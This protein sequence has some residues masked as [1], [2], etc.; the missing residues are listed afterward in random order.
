MRPVTP[1]G[2]VRPLIEIERGEVEQFL[3]D[4]G[5][6]W[7]EDASNGDPRFARN[8]IRHELLPRLTQENPALT[9]TLARQATVAA[10][11]E[12][13]WEAEIERVIEGRLVLRP[14]AVLFRVD[15]VRS[16]APAVARRAIRRAVRAA[17]GD[18]RSIDME[19]VERILELTSW[20]PPGQPG[21]ARLQ[22]PGLDV[23]RSFDWVRLAPPG[24]DTLENRNYEL[25]VSLPGRLDLPGG[26]SSLD[27]EAVEA[28]SAYN[29]DGTEL[30]WGRI[31]GGLRVR[32]WRPGDRYRPV[33]HACETKIKSLFQDARIPLWERRGWPVLVCGD[34]IVW[35]AKFGPAAEFAVS[36]GTSS[37]LK[38]RELGDIAEF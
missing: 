37:V 11:E 9:T 22:V 13:Y 10:D 20:R 31:S 5:V 12:R 29:K 26:R 3:R 38:V 15:W 16:L 7:R 14:P 21:S 6:A 18:L 25:S 36:P 23:F 35:T 33:G 34:S 32:N 1:E 27:V 17:K 24:I 8:R 30:D 2:L 19:H 28:G 4:R